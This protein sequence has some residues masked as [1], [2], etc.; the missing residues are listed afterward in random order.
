M[1]I[2]GKKEL[3]LTIYQPGTYI[4]C[5]QEPEEDDFEDDTEDDYLD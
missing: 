1:E 2:L 5:Y 4:L 3:E